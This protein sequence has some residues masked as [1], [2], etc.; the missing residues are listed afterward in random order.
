MGDQKGRGQRRDSGDCG[1][2]PDDGTAGKL[3]DVPSTLPLSV[4][5]SSAAMRPAQRRSSPFL[6]R[7]GAAG[8]VTGLLPVSGPLALASPP[9]PATGSE[10]N[11]LSTR[12]PA[13]SRPAAA[14]SA[15][16]QVASAPSARSPG[17]ST[18]ALTGQAAQGQGNAAPSTIPVGIAPLNPGAQAPS[19]AAPVPRDPGLT[20]Q[21]AISET[22]F[23]EL[24]RTGGLDRLDLL[25]RQ[26][27]DAGD[28][29]RLRLVRERLLT[30]HPAP[31]PLA[32]VLANA[33]VLLSCRM[34]DGALTVLDRIG[35]ARGAEQ[36]QWL[37]LQWRAANAAL[38]HRRAALALE[39]LTAER[40]A[41]LETLLL[42]LQPRSDGSWAS[43]SALEVLASHLTS[44]GLTSQAATLLL[45]SRNQDAAA[46]ERLAEAAR[47]LS[48]LPADQREPLFERAL[49]QAAAVGSWGLVGELLAAQAALPSSPEAAAR[50]AERR[51]RLSRRLDDAYGEWRALQDAADP[52]SAERRR[53]LQQQLRSP[54]S[55]GGHAEG[56]PTPAPLPPLFT[57]LPPTADALGPDSPGAEPPAG[58]APPAPTSPDLPPSAPGPSGFTV[59]SQP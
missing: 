46:A 26:L 40:P 35:P 51:L 14:A 33:E 27:V 22:D 4:T 13:A 5:G 53:A 34:P 21:A 6:L 31:Q 48:E 12:T 32:V 15:S 20:P 2:D 7:L 41:Q 43:R 17:V 59:P 56:L 3:S 47:L 9:Q 23:Q 29:T 36:V 58:D 1:R 39:R 18:E 16:A 38:D 25:C 24:L 30:I 42:P 55:P 50:T 52:A 37:T 44:A 11:A 54:R 57:A 10:A 28:D 45:L 49:E 19:M 8:L